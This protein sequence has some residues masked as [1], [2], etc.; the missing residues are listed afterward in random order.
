MNVIERRSPVVQRQSDN[1]R[2]DTRQ[3]A[4][5]WSAFIPGANVLVQ[6]REGLV[7]QRQAAT[8][9]PLLPNF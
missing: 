8:S 9:A 2:R 7:D 5:L 6:Y 1:W 3:R 4:G